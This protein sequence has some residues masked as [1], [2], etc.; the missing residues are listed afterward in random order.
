MKS[1]C[2]GMEF[3]PFT[4]RMP[5]LDTCGTCGKTDCEARLEVAIEA[6]KNIGAFTHDKPCALG[7]VELGEL[8]AFCQTCYAREALRKLGEET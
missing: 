1:V 4:Q 6:L 2:C 8:E 5:L 7:S 3:T